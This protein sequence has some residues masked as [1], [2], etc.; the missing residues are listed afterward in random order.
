MGLK[1]VRTTNRECLAIAALPLAALLVP[2]LGFFLYQW[3]VS[4][5]P[6]G[7]ALAKA[8]SLY[9][10]ISTRD[11]F[12]TALWEAAPL[13]LLAFYL[14][15]AEAEASRKRRWTIL[16]YGVAVVVAAE[17]GAYLTLWSVQFGVALALLLVSTGLLALR[18]GEIKRLFRR[19]AAGA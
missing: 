12:R 7:K 6:A 8:F 16:G 17:L 3:A 10:G 18:A 9:A 19:Q 1:P 14:L 2:L 5:L 13:A 15:W 11:L 4:M